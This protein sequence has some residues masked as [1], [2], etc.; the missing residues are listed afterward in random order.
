MI[1]LNYRFGREVA[2]KKAHIFAERNIHIARKHKASN[3]TGP[4]RRGR[5][6]VIRCSKIQLLRDKW[7]RNHR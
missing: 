7:I 6:G 3:T 4:E 1:L 5:D 2:K